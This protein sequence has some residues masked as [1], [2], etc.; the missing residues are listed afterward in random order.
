MVESSSLL[1]EITY[2][3]VNVPFYLILFT[4]RLV[5]ITPRLLISLWIASNI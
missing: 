1:A 5:Y 3:L 2:D 4:E